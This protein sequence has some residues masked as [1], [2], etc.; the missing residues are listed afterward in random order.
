M[1]FVLLAVLI[2]A[3]CISISH[4]LRPIVN[5]KT[6]S[7]SLHLNMKKA[8]VPDQTAPVI[9]PPDFRVSI[10]F[11][12]LSIAIS[13]GLHNLFVGI[14]VGLIGALLV[15]QTTRVRFVFDNEAMEVKRAEKNVENGSESLKES[16]ENFAVGGKNRWGYKSFTNWFFI[17]SKDFPILMYFTENQTSSSKEQLHLFPVIMNGRVLCDLLMSKVGSIQTPP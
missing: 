3:S 12:T 13:A 6:S 10:G 5:I 2:L 11:V 9:V 8:I 14:P 7:S 4:S 17:P 1:R 16:G 15:F